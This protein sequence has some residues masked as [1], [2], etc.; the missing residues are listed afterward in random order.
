MMKTTTAAER[1]VIAAAVVITI[2]TTAPDGVYGDRRAHTVTAGDV[3]I[4]VETY[5]PRGD[6]GVPDVLRAAGID[7]ADASY[8]R[9]PAGVWVV[10]PGPNPRTVYQLGEELFDAYGRP[11]RPEI[12]SEFIDLVEGPEGVRVEDGLVFG[13]DVARPTLVRGQDGL[14]R[15]VVPGGTPDIETTDHSVVG[16]GCE[17]AGDVKFAAFLDEQRLDREAWVAAAEGFA[18]AFIRTGWESDMLAGDRCRQYVGLIDAGFPEDFRA[19]AD[20]V[21]GDEGGDWFAQHVATQYE[22]RGLDDLHDSC[23]AN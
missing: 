23:G 1:K 20:E 21:E 7:G 17:V 12:G 16:R 13:L 2:D 6:W 4:E 15:V 11:T 9:F 3:T 18:A 19:W 8:A 14:R 5:E 10:H 22:W